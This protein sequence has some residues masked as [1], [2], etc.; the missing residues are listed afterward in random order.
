ME[1]PFI[2]CKYL[3]SI[4][5]LLVGLTSSTQLLDLVTLFVKSK[6]C[7]VTNFAFVKC[8]VGQARPRRPFFQQKILKAK[9]NIQHRFNSSF[10]LWQYLWKKQLIHSRIVQ[11]AKYKQFWDWETSNDQMQ[12]FAI[13]LAMSAYILYAMVPNE[14]KNNWCHFQTTRLFGQRF[15]AIIIPTYTWITR[16]YCSFYRFEQCFIALES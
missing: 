3:E 7:A 9:Q 11:K 4:Y 12:W 5:I 2:V 16:M 8:K 10:F 13:L 1:R 6:W 14:G 15:F